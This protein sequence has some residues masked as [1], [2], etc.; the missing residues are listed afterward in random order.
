MIALPLMF[1]GLRPAGCRRHTEYVTSTY[2]RNYGVVAMTLCFGGLVISTLISLISGTL[3]STGTR[4]AY[5]I[6]LGFQVAAVALG[7][8]ARKDELGRTAAITG[9]VLI[10]GSYF[11]L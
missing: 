11:L 4:P 10:V 1:E 8:F 7:I 2:T 6:F 5:P 3:S 9:A